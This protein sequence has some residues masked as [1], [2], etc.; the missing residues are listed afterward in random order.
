MAFLG[1]QR[2]STNLQRTHCRLLLIAMSRANPPQAAPVQSV[3]CQEAE[4]ELVRLPGAPSRGHGA[5]RA[6]SRHVVAPPG[7]I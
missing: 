6:G 1:S 2:P 3:P 5:L 4:D 7:A